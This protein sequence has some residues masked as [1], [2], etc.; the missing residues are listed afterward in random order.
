MNDRPRLT[1]IIP[2][3]FAGLRFDQALARVFPD[4]SRTIL[5]NWLL[6]GCITRDG[7]PGRP[8]DAVTGGEHVEVM[9]LPAPPAAD[10]PQAI[11]LDVLY[12]DPSLVVVNKPAGLVVH[13]GAG[14]RS[15]TLLNALLHL[16]AD[17]AAL[18]R[19]GIV[20]RLD[21][22][23]S[24]LMVVARTLPAHTS[25]VRQIQAR[26]VRRQYHAV[27]N[28]VLISGGT[29]DSPI[30]RHPVHRTKMA[31]VA[32]GKDAITHYRVLRRFRAHSLVEVTLQ[33]GRTHQIRVHM[34]A[35]GY[36][37]VGDTCY[38]GGSSVKR[39]LT[40][41]LRAALRAFGRQ[42]LHAETLQL[43]HPVS[44]ESMLWQA[45]LPAD[46]SELLATLQTDLDAEA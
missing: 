11:Q 7:Q 24:G 37:L 22:N 32:N 33:T 12:K 15:G 25:L 39:G 43:R 45:P 5:K 34:A 31:V 20:H 41:A 46:L 29:I 26:E 13:P 19:A 23:T 4:Y 10:E 30:G 21:K 44:S 28:H 38:G 40:P 8:R 14:N 18:P 2:P 16:D 27:V 9:V 17:L 6:A 42:A 3:D 1:A 36:P 35:L